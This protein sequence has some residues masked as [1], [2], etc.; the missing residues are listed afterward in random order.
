[1]SARLAALVAAA[2]SA[3]ACFHPQSDVTADDLCRSVPYALA[4][5]TLSCTG[6]ADL[7]NARYEQ[8][9]AN[10]VC[11]YDPGLHD[12]EKRAWF[13]CAGS[14]SA[15][16]CDALAAAGTDFGRVLATIVDCAGHYAPVNGAP[17]ADAGDEAD[18]GDAGDGGDA[19]D[20]SDGASDASDA[21]EASDPDASD[22]SDAADPDASD[23]EG[24]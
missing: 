18:A 3:S 8:F 20:A 1:M 5:R 2:L 23:A 6:D 16:D 7:A 19:A 4:S 12:Y 17:T 13:R 22:A 24:G 21:S 15:V 10:L 11:L 14:V 9:S